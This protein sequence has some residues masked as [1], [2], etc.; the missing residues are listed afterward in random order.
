MTSATDAASGKTHKDENFPVAS[1]L[2]AARHRPAILAFYHFVRAAD[3]VADHATLTQGRK[4]RAPRRARGQPSRPQRTGERRQAAAPRAVRAQP[5]AATCPRPSGGVQA[6][7]RQEPYGR[8]GRPDALLQPV[9]HAGRPL[10]A[11]RAWRMRGHLARLRRGLRGFADHQP[12]AGLRKGLP[13]SRSGLCAGRRSGARRHHGRGPRRGQGLSG[14][15][16]RLA[17]AGDPHRRAVAARARSCPG[18]WR[19]SGS[20]SRPR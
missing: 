20:A 15:A 12:P 2:I 17:R 8:L 16:R 13:R 3:D 1:H 4:I 9:G 18:R 6:R 14:A 11:R 10:R 19:I 7:R 5:F